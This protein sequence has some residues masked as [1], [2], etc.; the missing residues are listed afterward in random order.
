MDA[1]LGLDAFGD[2]PDKSVYAV[3]AAVDE[4]T[5]LFGGLGLEEWEIVKGF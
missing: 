5:E 4:L 3:G 1:K 2:G